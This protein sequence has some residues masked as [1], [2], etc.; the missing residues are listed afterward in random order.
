MIKEL[1]KRDIGRPSTYAS[2][3]KTIQDRGYVEKLN[4]ALVPT[5][6]GDVVSSFL[7]ANF[8]NYISDTFT[9]EMEDKLDLIAEGKAQY[10]KTLKDFYGP[11]LKDVKSKDKIDK[12]NNFGEADPLHACPIC[13]GPMIIKLGRTGKFLSCSRFPECKGA[14]TLD[15][16]EMPKDK[17]LGLD[18]KT[19][20][21]ITVKS[22]RFGPYVE[23]VS[24]VTENTKKKS[25][26]KPRR[27]SIPKD[28]DTMTINKEMAQK[29]DF[30]VKNRT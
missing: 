27:A 10:L 23:L 5:D 28:V 15:G 20:L 1:E 9:A 12:V 7:E 8:A 17:I 26:D 21:N 6:T 25:K 3:I 13:N 11:F 24:E 19:N 29:T 22:G 4:K 2:I 14:L 18:E 30:S 16:Q